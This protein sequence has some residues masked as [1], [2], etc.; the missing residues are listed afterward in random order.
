MAAY[1]VRGCER[2]TS[3][4]V[5]VW[6]EAATEAATRAHLATRNIDV[7]EITPADA[8]SRPAAVPLIRV[9]PSTTAP[10]PEV[11]P[12]RLATRMAI[13][14]G[15][16]LLVAAMVLFVDRARKHLLTDIPPL[17]SQSPTR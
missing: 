1:Q 8:T 11:G 2:L 6:V 17:K 12:R 7:L 14:V 10:A 9:P 13:G 16:G 4:T 5:D 15:L 3:R